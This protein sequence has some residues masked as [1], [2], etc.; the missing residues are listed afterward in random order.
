MCINIFIQKIYIFLCVCADIVA[1]DSADN[2]S[3]TCSHSKDTLSK[4]L[5]VSS[6][7]LFSISR[8]WL[9]YYLLA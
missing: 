1:E 8:P 5:E 6:I 7:T 2:S 4:N 3:I 9:P